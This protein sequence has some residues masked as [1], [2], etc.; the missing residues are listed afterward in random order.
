MSRAASQLLV[1][2]EGVED[3]ELVRRPREP[4]LLELAGHRDQPLGD[5]RNVIAR[6][7]APP[8]V[9]PCSAVGEDSAREDE[10]LLALRPELREHV[11]GFLLQEPVRE[12]ELGLDICLL[13]AGSDQRRIASRAQEQADRLREDRLSG[14]G[15]AGDGV[16]PRSELELGLADQDQVLDAQA[17]QHAPDGTH[18]VGARL[19]SARDVL[20]E[21]KVC[22]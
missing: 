1:A 5:R 6:R 9:G 15:L 20:Y 18:R 16:E 21:A 2:T 19:R 11:E 4:P 8:G 3:V 17:A 13:A 7:G 22:R 10:T 14:P 12:V